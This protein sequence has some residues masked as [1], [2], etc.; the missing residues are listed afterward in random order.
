M[1]IMYIARYELTIV[2]PSWNARDEQA[3]D[4]IY[5]IGQ[6]KD[7][8]IYRLITCGTIEE[9]I[10]RKQVHKMALKKAIIVIFLYTSHT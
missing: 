6:V 2:D 7:V 9:K 8:V 4:R 5:R 10:Y 1:C 3:V